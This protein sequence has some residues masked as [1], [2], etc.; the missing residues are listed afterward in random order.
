MAAISG[1]LPCHLRVPE[2]ARIS[3]WRV[4]VRLRELAIK[5]RDFVFSV[6]GLIAGGTVFLAACFGVGS[7]VVFGGVASLLAWGWRQTRSTVLSSLSEK[8]LRLLA[9][10]KTVGFG[11]H[12]GKTLFSINRGN[13]TRQAVDTIVCPGGE[14]D[15]GPYNFVGEQII[16]GFGDHDRFIGQL[17]RDLERHDRQAIVRDDFVALLRGTG[18]LIHRN[19]RN[20]FFAVDWPFNPPQSEKCCQML[21]RQYQRI[22][23]LAHGAHSKKIAIPLLSTSQFPENEAIRI[24]FEAIEEYLLRYPDR[25]DQIRLFFCSRHP[26]RFFQA[27]RALRARGQVK[28]IETRRFEGL[29]MQDPN[30]V[31]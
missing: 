26:H 21:K 31:E 11:L 16:E 24:A 14:S 1:A 5:I 2:G 20:L 27:Y 15:Y 30:F 9:N 13:I 19:I 8:E 29:G 25:F 17:R 18:N 7:A 3:L 12:I 28:P 22:L 10:P 4:S 6:W 23:K